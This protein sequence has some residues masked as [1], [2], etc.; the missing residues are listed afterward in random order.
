MTEG[1]DPRITFQF[2]KTN[3]VKLHCAEMGTGKPVILLHGFPELWYSW[4]AQIPALA[5][6]GYHVVAPDMRGYNLSDKPK[7]IAAYRMEE[8]TADVAGLIRALGAERAVVAGHDWG[9]AVAWSFA[10]QYPELLERLIILNVPHPFVFLKALKTF[11]QLRKSWYIFYFQLPWLPEM[12]FRAGNY[13]ALRNV[14]RHDPV[15]QGA[16]SEADI[17]QYVA[18]AAQPGALTAAINYYR[19][20]LRMN[21][22]AMRSGARVIEAPVLV[23]WGEQDRYIEPELA[24]PDPKW[25]NNVR[26]VR[27]P[28]ASHWLQADKPEE[29]NEQMLAFLADGGR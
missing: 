13:R 12:G 11:R 5:D 16:F 20:M 27:Y 8:L 18:A 26:V 29:V 7:G 23:L 24:D 1:V 3:Q 10:M 4:R 15:R 25:V 2:R 21:Q 9:A 14:F 19:A 17:D 28:D 6:A 22:S